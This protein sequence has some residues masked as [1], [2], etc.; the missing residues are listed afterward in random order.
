MKQSVKIILAALFICAIGSAYA[1]FT[2]SAY[3]DDTY[4]ATQPLEVGT[5]YFVTNNV[6][7]TGA[8]DGS[9]GLAVAPGA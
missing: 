2:K 3:L 1:G 6:T 7:F 5:V 9:S 8:Y 4:D